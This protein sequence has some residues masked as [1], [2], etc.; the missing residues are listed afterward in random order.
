MTAFSNATTNAIFKTLLL[1]LPRFACRV[2]GVARR[3]LIFFKR[4][5][6]LRLGNALGILARPF[7]GGSA[8]L[9]NLLS[10]SFCVS[11]FSGGPICLFAFGRADIPSFCRLHS[12]RV[13]LEGLR[14]VGKRRCAYLFQLRL[15]RLGC[16]LQAFRETGFF[17]RHV[18]IFRSNRIGG[19]IVP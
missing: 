17:S 14:A 16:G 4:C 10:P 8:F 15:L 9:P 19:Y 3:L 12:C 13:P 11:P 7:F 6:G 1:F 5:V 2:F 18:F